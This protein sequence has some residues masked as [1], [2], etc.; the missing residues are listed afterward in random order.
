VPTRFST[1][2][3]WIS[4]EFLQLVLLAVI[5]VGRNIQSHASDKRAEATYQDADAVLHEALQ[6]QAHLEA[7]DAVIERIVAT[8]CGETVPAPAPPDPPT[9]S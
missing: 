9:P 7:Q 1:I 2:V 6:I 5:I 4:S 8:V 3:L